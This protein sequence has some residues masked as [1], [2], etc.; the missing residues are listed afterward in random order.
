MSDLFGT[1]ALH[2]SKLIDRSRFCQIH[3]SDSELMIEK[4]DAKPIGLT[5]PPQPVGAGGSGD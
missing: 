4:N 3:G 5:I 1:G 2:E